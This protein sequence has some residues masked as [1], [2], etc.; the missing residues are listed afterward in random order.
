MLAHLTSGP[1]MRSH[2]FLVLFVLAW[3]VGVCTTPGLTQVEQLA[4]DFTALDV[5]GRPITLADYKGKK[6]VVLV[7]Y[8]GH[9]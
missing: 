1:R 5:S 9:T 6:L 4:P 3:L 7:F 2:V 8:I